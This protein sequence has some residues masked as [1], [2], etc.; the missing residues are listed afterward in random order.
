[1]IGFGQELRLAATS[2]NPRVQTT[3]SHAWKW[4]S[5][6][7]RVAEVPDSVRAPTPEPDEQYGVLASTSEWGRPVLHCA[8]SNVLDPD[9]VH[10]FAGSVNPTCAWAL[11][12][13][14]LHL[15]VRDSRSSVF[16]EAL[17]VLR[18]S[19]K[20]D[21]LAL[22][23]RGVAKNFAVAVGWEEKAPSDVPSAEEL[24]E[25]SAP[26]RQHSLPPLR[27]TAE[28]RIRSRI[29]YGELPALPPDEVLLAISRSME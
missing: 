12:D 17:D 21:Y 24:E 28:L 19:C 27:A 5:G 2:A 9:S 8:F 15:Q 16:A 25:L 11:L 20:S 22:V 6:V 14:C 26:A 29:D 3:P 1:M 7:E 23:M 13:P 18:R 4:R 10:V